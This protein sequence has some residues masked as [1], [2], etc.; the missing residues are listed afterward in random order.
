MR[1]L[2]IVLTGLVGAQFGHAH[3]STLQFDQ[4]EK[5]SIH[6]TIVKYEWVNP[7]VYLYVEE[8][9]ADGKAVTWQVEGQPPAILRRM[10]WSK[11]TLK[12]GDR[13]TANGNPGRDAKRNIL[14]LETLEK[15]DDS[16][17]DTA[18]LTIMTSLQQQDVAEPEPADSLQGTWATQLNMPVVTPL[19]LPTPELLTEKG[20]AAKED[21]VEVRDSPA[22]NCVAMT[23]PSMM[24]TPD[25]KEIDI[26]E[27]VVIIRGEFDAVERTIHLD[28]ESHD[29]ASESLHGYAIGHWDGDTLVIETAKFAPH[30]TGNGTGVPSG[31][32]KHLVERLQLNEART[33]LVYSFELTDPEYLAQPITGNEVL[34]THRPDLEYSALA[35][36]PENARRFTE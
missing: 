23:P 21:F 28:T 5:I 19:W 4:S 12:V 25:I 34:S 20:R 10:G 36:D 17:L 16:V 24:L 14:L 3:H 1:A 15:P 29:D 13:I 33:H 31:R 6:G 18:M 7:H 9:K 35:C 27:D 22:I 8:T 11:D 32:K 30:R 26:K 2:I